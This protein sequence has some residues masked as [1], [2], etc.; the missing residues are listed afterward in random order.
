MR[1][2][3]LLTTQ[4]CNYNCIMCHG[5]GLQEKK[6]D[7]LSPAD[8]AFLFKVGKER[9]G[10]ETTTLTGGEP[11]VRRDIITIAKNL[12]EEGAQTTLTTNGRLLSE[13]VEIG[14]FLKKVNVSIHSMDREKYEGIVRIPG[15]FD[16][17]M[18]GL[19]VFR[20]AN[21]DLPIVFNTTCILGVNSDKDSFLS[22]IGFAKDI[23][24]SIKNIELFPVSL[25]NAVRNEE[26]ATILS[27]MGFKPNSLDL[28]RLQ[29]TNGE[30]S[31]VLTK[32]FCSEAKGKADPGVF[33]HAQNDL[34]VSPDGKAKPCRENPE[35]ID[36]LPP[37]KRRD[38]TALETGLRNAF[39]QIGKRCV[40]KKS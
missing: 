36:L 37:I 23:G 25:P 35:E 6:K 34:F 24:A 27:G 12:Y 19:R 40:Y 1:E 2:I 22:L 18:A 16:R 14:G 8:F 31:V 5:E 10:M 4:K 33:C 32:I 21:P 26:V 30:T 13:R 28:R 9:M 29:F 38:T 11:L 39:D 17:T 20:E 7:L 15:S 3:R